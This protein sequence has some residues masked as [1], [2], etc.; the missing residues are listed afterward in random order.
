MHE[1][2]GSWP[3]C[4]MTHGTKKSQWIGPRYESTESTGR[5]EWFNIGTHVVFRVEVSAEFEKCAHDVTFG[6]FTCA[7]KRRFSG[8]LEVL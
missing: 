3:F 5:W 4:E 2:N 8:F 1:C 6:V 7:M